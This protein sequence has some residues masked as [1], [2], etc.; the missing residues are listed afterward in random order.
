MK[1]SVRKEIVR[2]SICKEQNEFLYLPDM[3]YGEKMA[4]YDNG[5]KYAYINLLEDNI[6]DDFIKLLT[7]ILEEMNQSTDKMDIRKLIDKVFPIACDK[8]DGMAVDFIS[9]KKCF[10]CGSTRFEGRLVKPETVE[11]IDL[12]VITHEEWIKMSDVAKRENIAVAIKKFM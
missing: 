7:S 11:L 9:R 4:S 5:S 6:Y 2:C 10:N 12:P 8:I 3:S 1:I